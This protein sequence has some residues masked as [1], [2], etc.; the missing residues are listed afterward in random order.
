MR[1][2]SVY[3]GI[4]LDAGEERFDRFSVCD[5]AIMVRDAGASVAVRIGSQIEDRNLCIR[6]SLEDEVYDVTA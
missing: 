2:G 1:G 5:V 3:H 6:V 4:W